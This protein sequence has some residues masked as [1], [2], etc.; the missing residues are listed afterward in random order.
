MEPADIDRMYR[1]ENDT[2]LWVHGNATRPFSRAVLNE[3]IV[4]SSTDLFAA[5][6][7][8]LIIERTQDGEA[9]GCIDLFEVD[10][11]HRRAGVGILIYEPADRGKGYG[12][13]ALELL[14]GYAI[15]HLGLRQLYAD[16][17]ES[18]L[19]SRRLFLRAG[20]TESGHRRA[21]VRT[22]DGTYED[23]LFMQLIP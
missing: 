18:N 21:W 11:L 6:Q 2:S 19:A 13:A 8:R 14:I 10:P 4:Q 5:G 12:L 3:L 22:E 1:W 17:P 15:D 7:L 16:V 20:F 23:A 9:V